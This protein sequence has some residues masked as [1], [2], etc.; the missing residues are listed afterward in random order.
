[1]KRGVV[2]RTR[3]S[4]GPH[5]AP[6]DS[7]YFAPPLVVTAAEIDRFIGSDARRGEGRPRRL[8][9]ACREADHRAPRP[10]HRGHRILSVL[11]D[12]HAHARSH[13]CGIHPSDRLA[14]RGGRARAV[15][16]NAP[17][18][19]LV[20]GGTGGRGAP[21]VEASDQ[22]TPAVLI[23]DGDCAMCRSSAL[24]LMR[25][26]MSGGRLEI[27]PSRSAPRRLRFP[28]SPIKRA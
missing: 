8:G 1:M 12:D 2:T 18:L 3:P 19:G 14:G 5:P 17:A 23:Y 24:W 25:L 6:G 11:R 21:P 20:V 4:P 22:N 27:L 7:V 10:D 9:R 26:A 13:G 16:P 15:L 28:P